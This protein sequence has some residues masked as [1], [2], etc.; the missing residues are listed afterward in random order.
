MST[1]QNLLE[2]NP[3]VLMEAAIVERL[4]RS[5]H[6]QLHP[7]LVHSTLLYQHTGRI[8]LARLYTEYI[9][10][11]S[12]AR[13]PFL[14]STPTWRAN[15]ERVLEADISQSINADAVK[16]LQ[17]IRDLEGAAASIKIGGTIGCKN[18]CYLPQEAL[19]SIDA[20][21]FHAWQ[22]EQLAQG[23][24]DYLIAVTLP[25]L[26]EALGIAR[27]MANTGVPY[28]ISF[29]IDRS[30]CVLDGTQLI[31][32]IDEIDNQAVVSPLGYMVNCS[33]P[34]F[35]CADKQPERLFE[36]FMG[37]SA[38]AS[39]LDHCDL[40]GAEQLES[41]GVSEWGDSMLELNERYGVR[42]LGGCCGTD[43]QHLK[44][45][46]KGTKFTQA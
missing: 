45:I 38:N 16:F 35:L 4:R 37:Y 34:T 22:I 21:Q 17:E 46:A 20:E 14:M 12:A 7:E 18:D 9:G 42:V 29:V 33:Y 41:E 2:D 26:E 28:F 40:D 19:T 6:V 3:L 5:K 36:R 10:V 23:G 24:V 27:A 8:E 1:L 43:A 15:H 13:L 30:G 32:A 31:D 11:A 25:A 39:S 44:Y